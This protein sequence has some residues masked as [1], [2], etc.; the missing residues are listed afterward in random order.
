MNCPSSWKPNKNSHLKLS[1]AHHLKSKRFGWMRNYVNCPKYGEP[2]F[3]SHKV[4]GT[5]S[6]FSYSVFKELKLS[7]C[8]KL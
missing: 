2:S 3:D 6:L 8:K 7:S 1:T 5:D 4:R